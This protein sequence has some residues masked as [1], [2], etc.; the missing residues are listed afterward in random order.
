MFYVLSDI[1]LFI[2]DVLGNP[3]EIF[4]LQIWVEIRNLEPSI[5]E[6]VSYT[7]K[8]STRLILVLHAMILNEFELN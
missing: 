4:S 3:L 6:M 5:R 8:E 1:C 7:K 2:E